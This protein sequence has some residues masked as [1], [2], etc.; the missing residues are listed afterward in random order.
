MRTT[1]DL[2]NELID[3]AMQITHAKTK[4][5]LIKLAL[6]NIIQQEKINKLINF[7]G[8]IDL[9]IDLNVLRKR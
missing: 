2:P 3:E 5:E 8:A 1:L 9:D 6:T 4:T 7:H